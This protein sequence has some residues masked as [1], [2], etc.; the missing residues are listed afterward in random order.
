MTKVVFPGSFDPVTVGHLSVIER[1]CSI[2]SEVHIAMAEN[3]STHKKNMWPIEQRTQMMLA[4][5][6]PFSNVIVHQ[7]NG[8]LVDFLKK[9]DIPL[10]IRGVRCANDWNYESELFQVHKILW[11]EVEMLCLASDAKFDVVSSTFVREIWSLGGNVSQLVPPA[12][13]TLMKKF[14]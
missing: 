5:V 4:A 6:S 2:F 8:L 3:L 13:L 12:V 11:P 1:S 10:I 7:F 9:L 14:K